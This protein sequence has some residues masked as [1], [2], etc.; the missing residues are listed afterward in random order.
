MFHFR[1]HLFVCLL[2]ATFCFAQAPSRSIRGTVHDQAGAVVPAARVTVQGPGYK[3]STQTTSAGDFSLAGVP[4]ETVALIVEASGFAHFQK[5][6][7]A[8]EVLADVVLAPAPVAQEVNVTANRSDIRLSDTAE[9]ISV[10]PRSAMDSTAAETVDDTLRQVPGF[11]LFR[12]SGSRIANPTSQGVSLRGIGASGASR[13]LVLYNGIP[14]NDPF[15]GWVYWGRIPSEAVGAM[16]VLR[17]GASS[18]YGSGALGGVI[19]ILPRDGERNLSSVD[20]SMGTEGTPEV[21]AMNSLKLGNWALESTGEV[22]RTAGYIV[23]P[24]D[25]RGTVDTPAN[26]YHQEVGSTLRRKFGAGDVFVTGSL[27]NEVRDNGT[28]VQKNDTQL[29]EVSG[30]TN[31]TSVI[32]NLQARGYGDGESFNQTFSSIALNRNSESLVNAQHVPAQRIGGSLL[33]S[34]EFGQRN[35]LVGGADSNLVR[36]FSNEETFAALRPT[37]HVS[38]GG[39]QLSSGVFLQDLVRLT[40]RLLL[41]LGGRYDSWDN[42]DAHSQTVPL[43]STVKPAFTA[44]PDQNKQAFSPRGALLYAVNTHLSLTASA[45]K[46]FRAPTLNELYR[47]FRLGN[48]VTLANSQL[49]AERLAGAESG[50]N[51]FFGRTR[52]HAAFFW[53]QVSD[54]IANVTLTTTPTLITAQ[55]QN[56][57][58][59]RT[60]GIETDAEWHFRKLDLRVGYQFADAVVTSFSANPRLLGLQI[61]QIA[62]HQF[63]FQTTYNMGAGWTLALQG[64]ASSSQFEDDLNTSVLDPYFQLDGYVSKR[65]RNGLETYLAAENISNSRIMTGRTPVVTV[66]PPIF[67][68]AGFKLHFE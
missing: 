18:L 5:S 17:G 30:G 61:P 66:G 48:T 55:R 24:S 37:S 14:L 20:V 45:Y 56:L 39:S 6:L 40:S 44:F 32:G 3:Q 28:V 46:S 53:M 54:P 22:F 19:N 7:P 15:G 41:T 11:T 12:R 58:R 42:Y 8:A 49:T 1:T 36:G 38:A 65:L 59:T 26:S 35:S 31:I 10:L 33:W 2:L 21:S 64:R 52:L 43:V 68:R 67:V 62:P 34:R 16:E 13:A 29:W 25:Q 27:Y 63:T 47:S 9:S 57:G 4:E 23:V 60:R 51:L 50:A